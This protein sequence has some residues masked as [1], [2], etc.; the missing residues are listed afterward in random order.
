MSWEDD[1]LAALEKLDLADVRFRWIKGEY[2]N[3]GSPK[4]LLVQGFLQSKEDA[5][6]SEAAV[7]KEARE[8]MS[9]SISRKALFNSR[10][11]TIIAIIAMIIATSDKF[12]SF[13]R[14]LG[15]LKP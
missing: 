8:E 1:L 14:W 5:A 7:R 11:A 9:L 15:I 12:I 3:I 13:L 4:Y 6:K 10:C 2:G